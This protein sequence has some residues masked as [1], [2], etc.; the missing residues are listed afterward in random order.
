M[1]REIEFSHE[2]KMAIM[3]NWDILMIGGASGCGKTSISHQIARHYNIDLVRV[4]DFQVILEAMTTPE[5]LP[6]LHYWDMHPNWR[7]E[8][9]EN[10]VKRL[11]DVG[12]VL[13]PGLTAVIKDHMDEKIPMVLEGDFI[14]P[15]LI[16]A[17]DSPRIKSVFIYEPSREQILQNYLAREGAVQEFRADVSHAY[18]NWLAQSCEKHGIQVVESRPWD[19]LMERV[20]ELLKL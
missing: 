7:D 9:I 18:G 8:G 19:S 13:I 20:Y 3:R 12:L 5:T 4:D 11:V 6:E 17:F 14:L 1:I 2:W 15:E 16:K 10:A